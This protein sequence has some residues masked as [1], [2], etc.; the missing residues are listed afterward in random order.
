MNE[1]FDD[2]DLEE[3]YCVILIKENKKFIVIRVSH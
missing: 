3:K 2:Y 1:M